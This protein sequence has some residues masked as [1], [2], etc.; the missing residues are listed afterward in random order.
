M[1]CRSP[2]AKRRTRE[3]VANLPLRHRP[4]REPRRHRAERL[5]PR[6]EAV[7]ACREREFN[8][9]E[10]F[11]LATEPQHDSPET[12]CRL[13]DEGEHRHDGH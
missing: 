1:P 12:I 5:D 2:P 3:R 8:L 7:R 6:R 11:C 4:R 13:P 10:P 9:P